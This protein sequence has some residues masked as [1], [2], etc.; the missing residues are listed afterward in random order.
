MITFDEK[1]EAAW[2]L[3]KIEKAVLEKEIA[4]LRERLAEADECNRRVSDENEKLRATYEKGYYDALEAA[5]D[6][7][8]KILIKIEGIDFEVPDKIRQLRAA[9][10]AISDIERL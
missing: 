3:H 4:E 8:A 7:S 10:A 9:A 2:G 5:A 1:L 6:L